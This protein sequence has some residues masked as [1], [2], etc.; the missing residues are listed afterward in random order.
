MGTSASGFRDGVPRLIAVSSGASGRRHKVV[1]HRDHALSQ[2]AQ[3]ASN[4]GAQLV[5]NAAA[6]HT[7]SDFA[8]RSP[9]AY[10][11]HLERISRQRTVSTRVQSHRA[12]SSRCVAE[13]CDGGAYGV[14]ALDYDLIDVVF[15]KVSFI[16]SADGRFGVGFLKAA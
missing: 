3:A 8:A 7:R 12:R 13:C 14:H 11:T 1:V 16:F 2:P 4:R 6:A 10:K 9:V 5:V 15:L